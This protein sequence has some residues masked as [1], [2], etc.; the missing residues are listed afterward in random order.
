MKNEDSEFPESEDD[1][2]KSSPRSPIESPDRG[3]ENAESVRGVRP[4][5]VSFDDEIDGNYLADE[6]GYDIRDVPKGTESQVSSP[7]KPSTS[8]GERARV[9]AA[10]AVA[11]VEREEAE[12][13]AEQPAGPLQ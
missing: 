5:G 9:A 1:S 7:E 12:E 6:A 3:A 2:L 13:V 11:E 8:V 4:L 10:A